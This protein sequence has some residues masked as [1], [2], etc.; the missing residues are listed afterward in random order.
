MLLIHG[1]GDGSFVWDPILLNLKHYASAA[2]DLRGHGDSQWD[3]LQRYSVDDHVEDAAHVLDTLRLEDMVLVGH[4]L[5]AEVALRLAHRFPIRVRGLVLV[6]WGPDPNPQSKALVRDQFSGQGWQY[7]STSEYASVLADR[8]PLAQRS[9][10]SSYAA[11]ALRVADSGVLELKCDPAL[12]LPNSDPDA[13]V[14]RTCLRSLNCPVLLVRG[15]ISGVLPER[16]ARR[17]ASETP[18][19]QLKVIENA[20]HAV[21]LDNPAGLSAAIAAFLAGLP[22]ETSEALE[23]LRPVHLG[24][25]A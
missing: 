9:V 19:C 18:R 21:P 8:L 10:L 11:N 12:A 20:G 4:S 22:L 15:A 2:L 7:A 3:P 1:F 14:L 5:G 24:L 23:P 16:I 17:M 25:P 6:D 13:N